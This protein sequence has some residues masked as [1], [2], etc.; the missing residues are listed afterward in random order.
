MDW[1]DEGHSFKRLYTF[2]KKAGW[3]RILK[4]MVV[5]ENGN[6]FK[7]PPE[8]EREVTDNRS[9]HDSLERIIESMFVSIKIG[10]KAGSQKK[11]GR[12]I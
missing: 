2:L 8:T 1:I 6:I 3:T 5:D 9:T 11:R 10:K 12:R 7:K 4:E